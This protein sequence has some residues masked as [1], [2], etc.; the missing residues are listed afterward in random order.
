MSAFDAKSTG[1]G[2]ATTSL[3]S[4]VAAQSGRIIPARV[5]RNE[6]YP[7]ARCCVRLRS[8]RCPL[9]ALSGHGLLHRSC[10]LVT[11]NGYRLPQETTFWMREFDL[12]R[13]RPSASQVAGIAL[14][15]ADLRRS[16][17]AEVLYVQ[18]IAANLCQIAD[19]GTNLSCMDF[20]AG[21]HSP[22]AH[23]RQPLVKQS[24]H[25][26]PGSFFDRGGPVLTLRR[27]GLGSTFR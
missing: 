26:L 9:S 11:Q 20:L 23:P 18:F 2:L 6:G 17:L 19:T 16:H 13:S 5:H 14:M 15:V 21:C 7:T 10:L 4:S 27:N 12:C 8:A 24:C 1:L 22:R 25:G 3:S